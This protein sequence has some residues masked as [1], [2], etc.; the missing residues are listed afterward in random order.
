M[1]R[2]EVPGR[3]K[4]KTRVYVGSNPSTGRPYFEYRYVPI[5]DSTKPPEDP[6][7]QLLTAEELNAARA[8]ESF[9][10]H[11]CPTKGSEPPSNLLPDEGEG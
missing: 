2:E 3:Q 7:T 10:S 6:P 1:E 5:Q 11:G 9:E 8:A 4:I